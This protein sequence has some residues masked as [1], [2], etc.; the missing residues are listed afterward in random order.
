MPTRYTQPMVKVILIFIGAGSG[1][2]LRFWIGGAVQRAASTHFPLGTLVVNVT[3]CLAI[4]ILTVLL[5][6]KASISQDLRDA[7]LIG[8]LGGYTT[9]ATFGRETMHLMDQRA[10][11]MAFAYV[12]TS[13]AAGFGATWAGMRLTERLIGPVQ[14]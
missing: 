4:G 10:Y 5:A 13:V 11:T 7:I 14:L 9:F 1:G 2:L 6:A 3:G 12:M 8:L